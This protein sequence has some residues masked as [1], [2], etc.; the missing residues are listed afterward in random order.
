MSVKFDPKS[1]SAAPSNGTQP[2]SKLKLSLLQKW[3]DLVYEGYLKESLHTHTYCERAW[4]QQT[5]TP[6]SQATKV[7]MQ[8]CME[9]CTAYK[10]YC[11]WSRLN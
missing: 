11:R 7:F 8:T 10:A 1:Q 6:P 2:P 3:T 4:V 5:G 9:D